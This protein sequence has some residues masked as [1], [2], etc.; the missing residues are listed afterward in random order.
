MREISKMVQSDRFVNKVYKKIININR[1]SKMEKHVKIET[2]A[3][4]A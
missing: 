4:N 1:L 3:M 2:I